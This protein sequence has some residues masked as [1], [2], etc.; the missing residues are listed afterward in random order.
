M[1]AGF[2]G[3]GLGTGKMETLPKNTS[4]LRGS[5]E[6]GSGNNIVLIFNQPSSPPVPSQSEGMIPIVIGTSLNSVMK[7]HLLLDLAYT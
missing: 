1:Q 6:S 3:A 2:G 7:N 4:N 5:G